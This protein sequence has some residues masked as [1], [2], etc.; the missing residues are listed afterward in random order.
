MIF[1]DL[2]ST[3]FHKTRTGRHRLTY[4]RYEPINLTLEILCFQ[5][6]INSRPACTKGITLDLISVD[7]YEIC[8]IEWGIGWCWPSC[9]NNVL[10]ALGG[11]NQKHVAWGAPLLINW[12]FS[13]RDTVLIDLVLLLVGG[14]KCLIWRKIALQ[15]ISATVRHYIH[16]PLLSVF[17]CRT[18]FFW[19]VVVEDSCGIAAQLELVFHILCKVIVCHIKRSKAENTRLTTGNDDVNVISGVKLPTWN[20][21][22]VRSCVL[23]LPLGV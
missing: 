1:A 17:V 23:T 19:H 7:Y 2:F 14:W 21:Y 13:H 11:Y 8:W 4:T 18:L 16:L 15:W 9:Y 10:T 3:H 12:G 20:Q 22:Q 5:H 6:Q